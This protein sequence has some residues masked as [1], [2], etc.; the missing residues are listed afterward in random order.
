MTNQ[1]LILERLDRIESQIA[2][3][4]DSVKS[5]KE[6]KDDLM[7]LAHPASSTLIKH[8]GEVESSFQLEDLSVLT[9]QF[10]RSV[11]N[12]TYALNQLENIIDF[13]KTAEPLL[14]TVIPQF[15]TYLDDLEQRGVFRILGATLNIRAKIADSYSPEDID[16]IGDGLVSLLG[17]AQKITD[18]RTL[19]VLEKFA[20]LPSNMDLEKSKDI[21]PFGLFSACSGKEAKQGLGV[22]LELTKAM[23][24]LK[25]AL[26]ISESVEAGAPS[27]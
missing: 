11:K 25:A 1:E 7:H 3:L 15:I 24:S 21:G 23:G 5:V 4:T 18:P 2:P 27:E 22:L 6:L 13:V 26:P 20:E 10:L 17:L 12:L 9:K 8:L 14:R 16:K 19:A